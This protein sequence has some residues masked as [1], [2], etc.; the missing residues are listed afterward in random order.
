MSWS[1]VAWGS[2]H[3]DDFPKLGD[4]RREVFNHRLP[5]DIKIDVKVDMSETVS[6]ANNIPPRDLRK[7]FAAFGSHI[8]RCLSY[9]FNGFNERQ[10]QLSIS[11]EG[12]P[13]FVLSKECSFLRGI[14]HVAQTD[15]VILLHT[16]PQRREALPA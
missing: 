8:S 4:Q 11:V 5:E 15:S 10:H 7:V 14:Q 13:G 12:T 9:D 3:L 6:H 16:A 2:V 1:I